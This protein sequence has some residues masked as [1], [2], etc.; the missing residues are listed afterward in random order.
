[1]FE[2]PV[3]E[4]LAEAHLDSVRRRA[5]LGEQ[6]LLQGHDRVVLPPVRPMLARRLGGWLVRAGERLRAVEAPDL[7]PSA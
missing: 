6:R 3:F 5:Q 2:S 1:M 4:I 7:Q